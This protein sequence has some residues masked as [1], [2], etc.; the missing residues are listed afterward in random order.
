MSQQLIQE[1]CSVFND[2]VNEKYCKYTPANENEPNKKL[3]FNNSIQLKLSSYLSL[4]TILIFILK[5]FQ[6]PF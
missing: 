3:K 2:E 6:F 4:I 1:H 5:K